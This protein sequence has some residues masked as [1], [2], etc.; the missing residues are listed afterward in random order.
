[1]VKT[2]ADIMAEAVAT[3][4]WATPPPSEQPSITLIRWSVMEAKTGERY[5]V[6]YNLEDLEGRVSTPLASFDASKAEA[7]TGSGR[8]YK[9]M[10]KPGADPDGLYVWSRV[11]RVRNIVAENVSAEYEAAIALHHG[12]QTACASTK[13]R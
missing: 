3:S 9:L 2:L 8:I 6:G 5:L 11:C 4:V 10:G 12:T 1:M 7:V 13:S